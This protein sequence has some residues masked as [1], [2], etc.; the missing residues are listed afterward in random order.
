VHDLDA[1]IDL[2][3][4]DLTV[5]G[6]LFRRSLPPI[7]AVELSGHVSGRTREVAT[8]HL[9]LRL[10]RTHLAGSFSGRFPPDQRPHLT[11]HVEVPV[12]YLD[13]IGIEPK[14]DS[15]APEGSERGKAGSDERLFA[16]TPLDLDW[17]EI[18]E[19][20]L[21]LHLAQ[22]DGIRGEVLDDLRLDADLAD[23]LL[24][25]R[26]L[27]VDVEGGSVTASLRMD[28]RASP[29]TLSLEGGAKGMNLG[30]IVEQIDEDKAWSGKVHAKLDLKTRG[31][32]LHA[33]AS[34]LDGV[35][36]LTCGAGTIATAHAGV[37]M[38][39]LF[40]S[41]RGAIGKARTS[42]VLNCL[43]LDF[44]F[45][46][47][48]GTAKTLVLDAEDVVIVGEG[49][50]DLGAETLDLR[51]V[52][53]P[54]HASPFSTA[55]TVT[56]KGPMTHPNVDMEKGTIV[57]STTK[58]IAGNIGSLT[59]IRQVW[60]ELSQGSEDPLCAKLLDATP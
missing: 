19:G 26:H 13:D 4:R 23:G 39:D 49:H 60:R 22:V 43:V 32:S 31:A 7:G 20:Q 44:A 35:V 33:L 21:T 42:E 3:A 16:D 40:Q 52:P 6:E 30:Q 46:A 10:D 29:P 15:E 1:Q 58:A 34:G 53:T 24:S 27:A 38:R 18:A 5:L 51:L 41:V 57:K 55:V 36:T 48:V 17:S 56:A 47:G 25:V 45:H 59:G 2:R 28:S 9:R 50:V 12:L 8:D 11:A 54:R 14:H 37:L